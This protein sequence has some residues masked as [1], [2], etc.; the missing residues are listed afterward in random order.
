MTLTDLAM[1]YQTRFRQIIF[2]EQAM[3]QHA[4]GKRWEQNMYW[5]LFNWA[6]AMH[7]ADNAQNSMDFHLAYWQSRGWKV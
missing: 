6:E 5:S 7:T 4:L 3:K 1:Y 2:L